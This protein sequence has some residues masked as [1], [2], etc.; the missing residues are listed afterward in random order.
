MSKIVLLPFLIFVAL[1]ACGCTCDPDL[2]GKDLIRK[3][4][5]AFIGVVISNIYKD[6]RAKEFAEE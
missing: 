3:S 4:E 1:E 2:K 5:Y 6:K